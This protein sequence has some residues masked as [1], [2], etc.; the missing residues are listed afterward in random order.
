LQEIPY[1][2]IQPVDPII[3][4]LRKAIYCILQ[5]FQALAFVVEMTMFHSKFPGG[6]DLVFQDATKLSPLL[7]V[8]CKV[9]YEFR[10]CPLLVQLIK[11]L[12]GI[13]ASVSI[14]QMN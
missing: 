13:I 6:I 7:C 11:A 3:D 4:V 10:A 5:V 8:F 1:C 9:M 14:L 12:Y 2:L